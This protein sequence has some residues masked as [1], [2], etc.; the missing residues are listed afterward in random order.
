M[1]SAG[2]VFA[3]LEPTG[4]VAMHGLPCATSGEPLGRSGSHSVEHGVELGP[5][6]RLAISTQEL[7]AGCA[8]LRIVVGMTSKDTIS[9]SSSDDGPVRT[10][11]VEV[12]R[13]RR[14]VTEPP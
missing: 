13:F 9:C 5:Y 2:A 4:H 11:G 12:E 10:D 6:G 1:P 14:A 3:H 8:L 7:P